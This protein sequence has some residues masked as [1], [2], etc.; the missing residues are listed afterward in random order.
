MKA[1]KIK[2]IVKYL[3]QEKKFKLIDKYSDFLKKCYDSF[4]INEN[5]IQTFKL[6]KLDDE[7][8]KLII[9]N[10]DDFNNNLEPNE[11]NEIIYI[12]KVKLKKNEK[13]NINLLKNDYLTPHNENKIKVP[14]QN[15]VSNINN[16]NHSEIE[17]IILEQN[18]KL[19]EDILNEVKIMNME[20]QKEIKKD[21]KKKINDIKGFLITMDEKVRNNCKKVD[22]INESIIGNINNSFKEKKT[23]EE[24]NILI[25]IQKEIK[26]INSSLEKNINLE[27]QIGIVKE[28]LEKILKEINNQS[29][30][31]SEVKDN[32]FKIQKIESKINSFKINEEKVIEK[33]YGCNFLNES[34]D[35]EFQYDDIIKMKDYKF[36]LTIINNGNL[37]WPKNSMLYGKSNDDEFEIKSIINNQN[38]ILPNQEINPIISLTYKNIKNE[39][40]K[41]I[42]P[43]KLVFQNES[44]NIKQN[45]FILQLIIKKSKE[46][47][48]QEKIINYVNMP[49]INRSIFG[50]TP[51]NIDLNKE[52]N[53][54]KDNNNNNNLINNNNEIKE[55]ESSSNNNINNNNNNEIKEY[56]SSSNNNINNNNSN[57]END[58]NN[59]FTILREEKNKDKISKNSGNINKNNDDDDIEKLSNSDFLNDDIF[60]KIKTKLEVDYDFTN[61]IWNDEELKEKIRKNLNNDL[62]NLFKNKIEEGIEKMVELLGE[63]LLII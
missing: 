54:Q 38:E 62:N 33:F 4:Q 7:N 41:Y 46:E 19:K 39:N 13:N 20:N 43:L 57:S 9:E 58:D 5:D 32:Q 28:K 23:N 25:N 49:P 48:N 15:N 35:L 50:V 60:Q 30:M 31:V 59:N 53:S 36:S 34:L 1:K 47:E 51:N 55:Y 8:D 24:N 26:S 21:L 16:I 11:N 10:E 22:D 6:Y 61:E 29:I 3:E 27:N 37:S 42:L 52:N 12:I 44:L 17:R 45:E 14:I 56:E 40:K 2:M 18:K 63:E